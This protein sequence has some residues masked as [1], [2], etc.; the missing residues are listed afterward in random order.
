MLGKK[1]SFQSIVA[2]AAFVANLLPWQLVL[3][4]RREKTLLGGIM[5]EVKDARASD[6][7]VKA[8]FTEWEKENKECDWEKDGAGCKEKSKIA[9]RELFA[10]VNQKLV[11]WEAPT[12][13]EV[14]LRCPNEPTA[15]DMTKWP[16]K[17]TQP[18]V[19]IVYG[20]MPPKEAP[21]QGDPWEA[22]AYES[23]PTAIIAALQ[24]LSGSKV[25]SLSRKK[26]VA[27]P[28]NHVHIAL[29]DAG[30]LAD[31]LLPEDELQ[32]LKGKMVDVYM[33]YANHALAPEVSIQNIDAA[34]K[35]A[36][37]VRRIQNVAKSVHVVLTG[38]DATNHPKD[39]S[40]KYKVGAANFH[41]AM[42][43]IAQAYILENALTPNCVALQTVERIEN[44]LRS[45][46]SLSD[47]KSGANLLKNYKQEADKL[48]KVRDS[49]RNNQDV[50]MLEFASDVCAAYQ[51]FDTKPAFKFQTTSVIQIGVMLTN[52]HV[53]RKAMESKDDLQLPTKGIK[54]VTG[55]LPVIVSPQYAAYKHF[56]AATGLIRV[57]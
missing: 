21:K 50:D 44:A 13:T 3:A 29:G 39:A 19:S 53:P 6:S 42:S 18:D 14:K 55:N 30:L 52:L 9:T 15:F 37:D 27:V 43:K 17:V 25:I 10:K 16:E 34:R 12:N 8:A 48:P 45:L 1:V 32:S 5:D 57:A 47:D 26:A 33:T 56:T 22:S 31:S 49:T 38:T 28:S 36:E 40:R 54:W 24:S 23:M 46:G 7:D 35:V 11:S 2:M 51:G 4:R 20:G 41:Y